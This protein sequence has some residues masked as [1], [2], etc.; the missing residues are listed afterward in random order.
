MTVMIVDDN[1]SI[2][3]VIRNM[4][5]SSADTFCDCSD[6]S[7]AL[8]TYRRCHPDWVL[9]DIKMK[10]MD[11]FTATAAILSA[12]PG[13]KIIMV[14]QFNDSRLQAKAK[15]AGAKAFV[16]KENLIDVERI[17]YSHDN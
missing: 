13:A 1:A 11:G 7:E 3:E 5:A 8:E 15:E 2:R 12:F 16:L 9:M 6:G 14:T 10:N 17:M 4:L